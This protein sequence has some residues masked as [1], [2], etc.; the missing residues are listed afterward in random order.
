MSSFCVA[1]HGCTTLPAVSSNPL[2]IHH[3]LLLVQQ[4]K[5]TSVLHH[6]RHNFSLPKTTRTGPCSRMASGSMPLA[7]CRRATRWTTWRP[8]SAARLVPC[9]DGCKPCRTTGPYGRTHGY[10]TTTRTLHD[11][12]M[13]QS[14]KFARS[15]KP[16]RR[17]SYATTPSCSSL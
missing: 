1:G 11:G 8:L 3:A 2:K 9:A 12:T 16:S 6:W 13:T 5:G 4:V 7:W 15:S 10:E 14:G 17:L